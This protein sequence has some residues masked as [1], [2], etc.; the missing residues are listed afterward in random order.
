MQFACVDWSITVGQGILD[1]AEVHFAHLGVALSQGAERAIVHDHAGILRIDFGIEA[2][3]FHVVIERVEL[4][5]Q[6]G[7]RRGDIGKRD[8]F[9]NQFRAPLGG[10]PTGLPGWAVQAPSGM[11]PKLRPALA[12]ARNGF[13]VDEAGIDQPVEV[14]SRRIVVKSR[15]I[16]EFGD[17]LPA[18]LLKLAE[19]VD[20][21]ER[22]QRSVVRRMARGHTPIQRLPARERYRPAI[23][24]SPESRS[25]RGAEWEHDRFHL[26]FP[27]GSVGYRRV[28]TF[29]LV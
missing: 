3:L 29:R 1:K 4:A 16:G 25:A 5:C 2:A 8:E 6:W 26:P 24:T 18:M 11:V 15:C 22:S 28:E 9:S 12:R 14:L 23:P 13:G 7:A 20:P 17:G 10:Q 19:Q 27:S 21:A